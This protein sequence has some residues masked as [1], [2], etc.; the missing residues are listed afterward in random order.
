MKAVGRLAEADYTGFRYTSSA[1]GLLLSLTSPLPAIAEKG[2]STRSLWVQKY[3]H[4]RSC[5]ASEVHFVI[6][7]TRSS[8]IETAHEVDTTQAQAIVALLG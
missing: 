4:A 2:S 8:P 1:V 5:I 3:Y 7:M 6:E